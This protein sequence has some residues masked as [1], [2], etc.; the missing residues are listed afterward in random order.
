MSG[1]ASSPGSTSRSTPASVNPTW[2]IASV[3]LRAYKTC[4]GRV[5]AAF[6]VVATALLLTS[7]ASAA[8]RDV[9][10]PAGTVYT[11]AFASSSLPAN[12]DQLVA[13]AGGKILVR[14]PEIGG[15]GVVSSNPGFAAAMS[16]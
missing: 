16:A 6:A 8:T 15:L 14:L 11:V 3:R 12:V 4:V 1:P 5:S 2:A 9:G 13:A 10:A 7:A